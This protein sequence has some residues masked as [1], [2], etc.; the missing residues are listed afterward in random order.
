MKHK[1]YD[2]H[3][4]MC[5]QCARLY[6]QPRKHG[7]RG[8]CTRCNRIHNFVR[9]YRRSAFPAT[10]M[11]RTLNEMITKGDQEAALTPEPETTDV[12]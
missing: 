3:S 11:V 12:E 7:Y 5:G 4:E 1:K 6:G 10:E 2:G 9:K 8:I